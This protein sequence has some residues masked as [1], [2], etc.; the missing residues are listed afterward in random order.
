MKQFIE[1]NNETFE[2]KKVKGKLYPLRLR[3][4]TDCYAKPSVWKQSI[5]EEWVN[6]LIELNDNSTDMHFNPMT[7]IS[8]N[9][10]M[11][12]LGCDVYNNENKLIGQ[13]YITKTRQEFWAV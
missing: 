1:L 13:I 2:V 3:T 10:M 8:Y 11:F 4:L 7:V 12:T 6:W 9:T 5:Y